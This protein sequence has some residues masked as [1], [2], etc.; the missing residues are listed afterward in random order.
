MVATDVDTGDTLTFSLANAVDGFTLNADG[1]YS[2]EPIDAAYQHLAQGL[3]ETLTIPVKRDR[4][5]RRNRH[6]AAGYHCQRSSNDGAVISGTDA[7]AVTEDTQLTTAGQLTVTDI[8]DQEA[9]FTAQTKA[10]GSYGSFT[11]AADGHWTYT[12]DNTNP[13]V[14]ALSQTGTLTD[15]LTVQSVDGTTHQITVTINGHD[16]GAVIAG[17]D[18]GTVTEDANLTADQLETHG[19]LTITDPDTARTTSP[20]KPM[21]AGS[22]GT[23]SLD[24]DGPVALQRRQQP[25]RYPAA[26]GG[27]N[28]HRQYH[29]PVCGRHDPHSDHH[30]QRP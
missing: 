18:S 24:A 17:V 22:Y 30:H 20:H 7:G 28:P 25:N 21:W 8:D 23:F 9:A 12:L 10:A 19:K 14:Q 15:S 13:T 4:Q 3:T 6:P 11:L 29:R 16:D 27:R 1:S 5:C 2:F 26:Q